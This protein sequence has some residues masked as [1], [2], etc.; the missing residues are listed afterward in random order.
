MTELTYDGMYVMTEV[1]SVDIPKS[2]NTLYNFMEETIIWSNRLATFGSSR[3]RNFQF[4]KSLLMIIESKE[5]HSNAQ[6]LIF[7]NWH[8]TWMKLKL[9]SLLALGD[10]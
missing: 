3:K 2:A 8:S 9:G 4:F 1:G 7:V 5:A 10:C 6:H